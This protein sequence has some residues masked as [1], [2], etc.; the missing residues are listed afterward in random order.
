MKITKLDQS[1]IINPELDAP[2]HAM[3]LYGGLFGWEG[4]WFLH[5]IPQYVQE[6]TIFCLPKHYTNPC[7]KCMDELHSIVSPDSIKSYSLAGYSR[8]GIEVYRYRGLREWRIFGLIDP[9]APTLGDFQDTVLDNVSARIRCVYWVPNWGK[10][11]YNGRVPRFAQ[12]L[13]DLK[14]NMKEQPTDHR[15]MPSLFFDVYHKEFM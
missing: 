3:V 8:G 12:H 5:E 15:Y 2:A 6:A 1:I 10:D 7:Q 14:V 4:A 9:S 13:R 11:G